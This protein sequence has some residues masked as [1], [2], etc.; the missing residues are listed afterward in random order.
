MMDVDL[1][2]PGDEDPDIVIAM[3]REVLDLGLGLT[4]EQAATIERRLKERYGDR[5]IRVKKKLQFSESR[6]NG[7][8]LPDS[9]RAQVYR[10]GLTNMSNEEITRKHGVSRATIYRW[11]KK[12]PG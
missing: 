1:Q 7:V 12:P 10:D 3:I 11:M 4:T 6:S 9:V 2:V 5:R 8:G